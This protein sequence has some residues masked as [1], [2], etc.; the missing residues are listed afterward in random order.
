[1]TAPRVTPM[2]RKPPHPGA[3]MARI[4]KLAAAGTYSY[5][6]HVFQ[7][8]GERSIDINDALDV[9]RLGEIDGPVEPGVNAGEWKCKVT[10]KPE[11]A[12]R[13]LGVAVVVIRDSELF[14]VTVEWEDTK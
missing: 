1:M 5:G 4:R 13:E 6:R 12:N 10:A 14:L 9:L 8:R 7:R 11:G 3:L 2:P